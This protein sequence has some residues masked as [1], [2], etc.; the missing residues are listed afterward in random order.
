[1]SQ[2]T[3]TVQV[4]VNLPATLGLT[5]NQVRILEKKWQADLVAATASEESH[6]LKGKI[7]FSIDLHIHIG[8]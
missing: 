5:E 8:N 3:E 7:H 6:A 2:Q 4:A 1:M